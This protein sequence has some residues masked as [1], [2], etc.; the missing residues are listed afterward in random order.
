MGY[1]QQNMNLVLLILI[2]VIIIAL[3]GV[4][5]YYQSTYQ[6]IS[7]EFTNRI[8]ELKT[9]QDQLTKQKSALNQ[10]NEQ[11]QLKEKSQQELQALY[12]TMEGERNQL[13]ADKDALLKKLET[14]ASERDTALVSLKDTSNML[15]ATQSNLT[16]ARVDVTRYSNQ[17]RSLEGKLNKVKNLI[18]TIQGYINADTTSA[19]CKAILGDIKTNAEDI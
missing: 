16:Q 8:S 14:T 13:Q 12:T 7:T 6:N 15:L 2:A 11:L 9:T 19:E 3:A 4:T 10:T 5:V 18:T 17:V 1:L